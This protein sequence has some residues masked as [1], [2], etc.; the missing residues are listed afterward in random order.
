MGT[1]EQWVPGAIQAVAAMGQLYLGI[2]DHRLR[3]AEAWSETVQE[4]TELGAGG[5]PSCH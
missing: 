2:A 4:L 3:Q 5:A 1:I